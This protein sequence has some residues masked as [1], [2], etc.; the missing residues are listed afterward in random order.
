MTPLSRMRSQARKSLPLPLMNPRT[1]NQLARKVCRSLSF[2]K[3]G[4]ILMTLTQRRR[5][6]VNRVQATSNSEAGRNH[7]T[8]RGDFKMRR[9]DDKNHV[10]VE[11]F[12]QWAATYERSPMQRFLFMPIHSKM[13]RLLERKRPKDQPDFILDVGC[14]TGRLLRAVA[15]KWPKARLFGVDPAQQM[16]SEA[17][18]LNSN[19]SFFLAPAESLPFPDQVAD[20]VLSSMSFHHWADQKRGIHEIARVLRQGGYFCLAD[21]GFF[22]AKI[23][24]ES[25]K[26]RK[27][28]R[29]LM[30]ALMIEEGLAV[31]YQQAMVPFLLITLAQKP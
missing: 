25:V 8:R 6:R 16:V 13:L 27:E 12:D 28:I 22:P 24:G 7:G 30:R 2:S 15:S 9:E 3:A 4:S 10:A 11:R 29:A 5:P 23:F 19:A 17:Q 18:R 14:G 21:H 20:I 26:S 31:R 1:T